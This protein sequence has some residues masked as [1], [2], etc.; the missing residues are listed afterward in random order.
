MS[1][2]AESNGSDAHPEVD[3]ATTSHPH[4][5]SKSGSKK[6]KRKKPKESAQT[7]IWA[8]LE[9]KLNSRRTAL[10]DSESESDDSDWDN[11]NNG[12]NQKN[13]QPTPDSGSDSDSDDEELTSTTVQARQDIK[14][15]LK[16][17]TENRD[18]GRKK[19][20]EL[21]SA[22]LQGRPP[23]NQEAVS[24][25][26]E[27]RKARDTADL[28]R[29]R[30]NQQPEDKTTLNPHQKLEQLLASRSLGQTGENRAALFQQEMAQERQTSQGGATTNAK[31]TLEA[32]FRKRTEETPVES[33]HK[34]TRPA[35]APATQPN[36]GGASFA[37]PPLLLH[38][39]GSLL[40]ERTALPQRRT[41]KKR[42]LQPYLKIWDIVPPPLASR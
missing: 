13:A 1:S 30:A 28:E 6:P 5:S 33:K 24:A 35:D 11:D 4:S 9:A 36:N 17:S 16:K 26:K 19:I 15:A 38:P 39:E 21:L 41:T 23:I 18:A 10:A 31:A 7:G 2:S 22:K 37:P 29:E 14:L 25:Q 3:S 42:L 27:G 40:R 8:S 34:G 20:S 32:H 12:T